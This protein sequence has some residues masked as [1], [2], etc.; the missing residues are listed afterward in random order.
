MALLD[1]LSTCGYIA[2]EFVINLCLNEA[3][4]RV[5]QLQGGSPSTLHEAPL[6]VLV[7]K[8]DVWKALLPEIDDTE[9]VRATSTGLHG[10]DVPRV[11]RTSDLIRGLLN[12]LCP[13]IVQTA[14]S[15]CR[16]VRYIPVTALGTSPRPHSARTD[17]RGMAAE[18]ITPRDIN[19][20][21]VP[22]PF[23]YGIG[24]FGSGLVPVFKH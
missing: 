2:Q 17:A 3:A 16:E 14:E 21:W 19:P 9:P 11:E 13:T 5:R 6:L 22:V 20:R 8:W 10:L 12:R 4:R 23:L 18:V 24:R 15:F 7:S 1:C